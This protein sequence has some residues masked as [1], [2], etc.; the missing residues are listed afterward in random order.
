LAESAEYNR[1]I[2]AHEIAGHAF[3]ARA[4]GSIVESVTVIPDGAHAGHCVRRGAPSSLNVVD[5]QKPAAT[6]EQLVN[7]CAT[8]GAPEI[9]APRVEFAEEMARALV[10]VTELVAGRVAER[11]FFPDHEPLSAEH[12]QAEA[13]ALASTVSASPAALLKY[14]EAEA[15]ALIRANLPIVSALVDELEEKGTLSGAQVDEVITGAIAAEIAK[16][17]CARRQEWMRRTENAKAF[18]PVATMLTDRQLP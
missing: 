18:E 6:T 16:A 12:D 2:C 13:H 9:G 14:C 10:L 17:E 3:V 1:R 15:E 4:C 8:I 5:E 7:I 11:I